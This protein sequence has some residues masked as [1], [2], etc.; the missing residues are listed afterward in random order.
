VP[1]L[2][3]G[4]AQLAVGAAAIFARYALGGAG[5][6]AVAA[7]RLAIAALVLF[8]ISAL[9]GGVTR[10]TRRQALLLAAAGAALA[11]H[12]ATW[13]A[14]LQ[15]A[16]VAVSTL[17]VATTPVFTALYDVLAKRFVPTIATTAA[18][19]AGAIGLL[20][21]V[22]FDT[23]A[24]PVPHLAWLGALL[25]LAGAVAIGAYFVLV[26]E[27]RASLGTRAIVTHTYG[28]AAAVLVAAALLARQP[29]PPLDDRAAWGGILAMALISQLLGHTA[30]N[31]SLRWFSPSAVSFS[32]L[33]EP[34][35]AAILA[36]L[37]LGEPVAAPAIAGGAVLLGAIAVV[38]RQ[39]GMQADDAT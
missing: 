39:E 26:R 22:G 36:W 13:I 2:L 35:S 11:I 31:A 15:F 10:V 38:L 17:L 4:A 34:V 14:S 8:V 33:L 5:P 27:V 16:S 12:F 21:V 19:G 3:L 30:F 29:P 37:F 7:S 20:M 6:L 24:A 23:A 18:F 25:A 32:T 1:Y 28:W 9:R